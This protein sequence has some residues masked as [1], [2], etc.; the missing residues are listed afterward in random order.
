[1]CILFCRRTRSEGQHTQTQVLILLSVLSSYLIHVFLHLAIQRQVYLHVLPYSS[2]NT[3]YIFKHNHNNKN[4][5]S[6]SLSFH[7]NSQLFFQQLKRVSDFS[8]WKHISIYTQLPLCVGFSASVFL[9]MYSYNH[10]ILITLPPKKV[11]KK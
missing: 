10:L 11:N 3:K 4:I 8:A 7:D 1:M 5:F 9:Y 6:L 2:H